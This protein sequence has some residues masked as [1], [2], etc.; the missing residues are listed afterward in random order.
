MNPTFID[1]WRSLGSAGQ[2][3]LIVAILAGFFGLLKILLEK[4]PKWA[5]GSCIVVLAAFSI[6]VFWPAP[7][8][9]P[10]LTPAAPPPPAPESTKSQ[11]RVDARR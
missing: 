11:G 9:K 2:I 8:L 5:I 10:V 1:W 6:F 4:H 7:P 3:T